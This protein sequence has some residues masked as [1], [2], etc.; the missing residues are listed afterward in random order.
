MFSIFCLIICLI[1]VIIPQAD[2]T[3]LKPPLSTFEV[4]NERNEKT[5]NY[6]KRSPIYDF[7]V[8]GA[9]SAGIVVAN[10][11]SEIENWKVLLIEAG[12]DAEKFMDIPAAASRLQ[13]MSINWNYRTVPM[14]NSCLSFEERRCKFPRGKVMG[15]SSTLNYMIYTRGNRKDY[16]NWAKMGNTG[17]NYD[18]VLKYFIKS[19]NASVSNADMDYR[20]QSGLLSVSDVPYRTTIAKA[21]VD[22]GSQIGLPVI[23]VNGERQVGINYIQATMKDGR[24][25]STNTAFLF[26]AKTRSNLFVKKNSMVTRIL[27]EKHS[28]KAIGVEFISKNKKYRVF[29]KKEVIISAGAINSPQLLMLSGIG[30]KWHL[31]DKHI[32]LVENLPVGENLMD[33][34][35]LGSLS[36]IINDTISLKANRILSNPLNLYTFISKHQGP[37]TIP[38]G[39]EALAFIDLDQPGF[40]NGHPNLELLLVSGLYSGNKDVYRLFGLETHIYNKVYRPTEKMDG[41]IIFPMIMRPKSKGRLWLEDRNPFHHPLIDPNYFTDEAD[42]DVAVAGVRIVQKMLETDAMKKLNAKILDTPLPGCTQYKFDTDEYWKC[43][44][45]QI[46]FTIYHQSGTC[47][48]GPMEDPTTVVDPKLRVHGIQHLRIIDAS[49][50]PEIPAAHTNGP[51]IMIGEKGADMIKNDWNLEI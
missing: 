11:L 17:W 6:N 42:L 28:K 36:I 21:F 13:T 35:A 23:D 50:I 37:F 18:E 39:A 44:A 3:Y 32:P 47:K 15:G 33:H 8:V 20:G 4:V 16:D 12:Q 34:V 30:P 51:T 7:V 14:N 26:S 41:F 5:Q 38:G 1:Y 49:I 25:C 19:E 10:R 9:G 27:I 29:I 24:R 22:A 43:S 48:M 45:K 2:S 31:E 40:K 46:S